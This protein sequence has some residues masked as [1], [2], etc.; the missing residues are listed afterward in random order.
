MAFSQ[1]LGLQRSVSPTKV[2]SSS[3][4][5]HEN[6]VCQTAPLIHTVTLTCCDARGRHIHWGTATYYVLQLSQLQ[7]TIGSS[8]GRHLCALELLRQTRSLTSLSLSHLLP[9]R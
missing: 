1:R 5:C 3:F 2:Q 9:Q 7:P 4:L 8:S 6:Y